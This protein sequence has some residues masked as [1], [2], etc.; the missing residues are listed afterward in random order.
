MHQTYSHIRRK[1]KIHRNGGFSIVEM[2]A[3]LAIL[4]FLIGMY[5]MNTIYAKS[6]SEVEVVRVQAAV[7]EAGLSTY[8]YRG[9]PTARSEW[10]TLGG[11]TLSANMYSVLNTSGALSRN[12]PFST[13]MGS[14]TGYAILMPATVDGRITVTREADSRVVYP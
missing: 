10:E 14:F 5:Y 4:A 11:G 9:G 7:L 8:K 3:I 13:F 6:E 2:F 12:V 1:N